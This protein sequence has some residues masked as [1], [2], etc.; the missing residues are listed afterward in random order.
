MLQQGPGIQLHAKAG[1]GPARVLTRADFGIFWRKY[2][3][4]IIGS[5]LAAVGA[6][7]VYLIFAPPSYVGRSELLIEPLKIQGGDSGAQA[8][9]VDQGQVESQ[10]EVLRSKKVADDVIR[11]LNLTSDPELVPAKA[12][13][14]AAERFRMASEEFASRL[15]VRRIGQSYVVEVSFRASN[16][17]K[18]A[19]IVNAVDDAYLTGGWRFDPRFDLLGLRSRSCKAKEPVIGIAH[20]VQSPE[21]GVIG[22]N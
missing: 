12:P 10:V 13:G 22:L 21:V 9:P 6:A 16:P 5:M 8:I 2:A 11:R 1:I 3:R 19:R 20:V 17:E 14:D 15:N 7:V 4:L 18:A